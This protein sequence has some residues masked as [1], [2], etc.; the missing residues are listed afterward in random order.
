MKLAAIQMVSGVSVAA[1][2]A[3]ASAL[4]S[5]AA[6]RG[7]QFVAL[8]ENFA[9]MAQREEDKRL[10]AEA[11]DQGPIQHMLAAAARQHGIWLLS[12]TYPAKA[13]GVRVRACSKLYSPQGECVARYDK[14]H[15]FDVVLPDGQESYRESAGMEPGERMVTAACGE[16]VLGMSV[17][18]DLRFPELFRH[19]AAQGATLLSVPAAFTAVTGR[20]HWLTLLKARAIENLCYVIAPGQGGLHENGRATYGHSVIIDPWGEVLGEAGEGEAVVI[21]DAPLKTL[22]DLRTRFPALQHRRIAVS[23]VVAPVG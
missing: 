1:N 22:H 20:A 6:G 18:Y 23:D 13:D 5:E 10:S 19:Y 12:G 16:H 2:L 9:L 4:I 17:C 14:I 21:A 15:L 11:D 3:R 7:A 8:P